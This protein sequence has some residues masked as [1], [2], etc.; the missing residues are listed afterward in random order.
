MDINKYKY[1]NLYILLYPSHLK[2][3]LKACFVIGLLR[4]VS[5]N[6]EVKCFMKMKT[7]STRSS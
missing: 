6:E 3:I 2:G 5:S 4:V 1:I 7:Y